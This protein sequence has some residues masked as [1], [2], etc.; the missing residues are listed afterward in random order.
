MSECKLWEAIADHL[1]PQFA[2]GLPKR[3]RAHGQC[4]TST[5]TLHPQLQQSTWTFLHMDRVILLLVLPTCA[6]VHCT[7]LSHG[8]STDCM[9]GQPSCFWSC[10]WRN[11]F[12]C[13]ILWGQGGDWCH[14]V[15]SFAGVQLA[16]EMSI[17][18]GGVDAVLL[19][20]S[21]THTSFSERVQIY[22]KWKIS[23]HPTCSQLWFLA[24][25]YPY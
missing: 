17:A 13:F 19:S 18:S 23:S 3:P 11:S 10:Q 2:T 20:Q 14:L 8:L 24:R 22:A 6:I 21:C 7:C 16:F 12:A 1:W 15:L 25:L 4:T 5:C 9:W